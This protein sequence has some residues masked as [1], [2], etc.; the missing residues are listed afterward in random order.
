MTIFRYWDFAGINWCLFQGSTCSACGP[1][2][3]FLP[4]VP[5]Q[6]C[7]NPGGNFRSGIGFH[8]SRSENAGLLRL[9]SKIGNCAVGCFRR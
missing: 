5:T 9:F 1:I 7:Y 4:L 6:V 8:W 3:G 2:G